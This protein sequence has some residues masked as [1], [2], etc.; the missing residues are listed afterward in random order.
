MKTKAL[1]ACCLIPWAQMWVGACGCMLTA[2][3]WSIDLMQAYQFAQEQDPQ[4]RMATALS[5]AT[6]ERVPQAQ[7]QLL[8]N[9]SA[10][11]TQAQNSLNTSGGNQQA[12]SRSYASSNQTFSVRQALFRQNLFSQR[13][14]AQYQVQEGRAQLRVTQQNLAVRVSEAYLNVLLAHEQLTLI[15]AQKQALAQVL[16]AAK[17]SLA[18]GAGV[19][20]DVDDAQAKLDLAISQELSFKQSLDLS[21]RQLAVLINQPVESLAPISVDALPVKGLNVEP[22]EYFLDA[23]ERTSPELQVLS[24]QLDIGRKQVEVARAGHKPTVDGFASVSRSVSENT[25]LPSTTFSQRQIGVQLTVPLYQGGF[26]DSQVRESLAQQE[27]AESA[28][29]N[30]RRDL[31][32]RIHKEYRGVTEGLARIPAL[33]QTVKSAAQL[34]TSTE[35]GFK[36]GARTRVDVLNA[37]IQLGI[38]RRDLAQA[39]SDFVASNIRLRS[40]VGE[41]MQEYLDQVNRWMNLTEGIVFAEMVKTD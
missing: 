6:E 33:E 22:L 16:V 41:P 10:T 38:A 26:V 34:I 18:A 28:L 4:I 11:A 9:V 37:E 3:A 1:K 35:R 32:I 15:R 14:L 21:R 39:R 29:E 20:T 7:A 2:S 17:R 31:G 23:A 12:A 8:P 19:R 5:R 25:A 30:G 13:E 24:A 40:L 27:R 36:A